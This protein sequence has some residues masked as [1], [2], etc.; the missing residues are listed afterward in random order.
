MGEDGEGRGGVEG[1]EDQGT[2]REGRGAGQRM[3]WQGRNKR[4]KMTSAYRPVAKALILLH[5]CRCALSAGRAH[6]EIVI[7]LELLFWSVQSHAEF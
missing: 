1:E 7:S 3:S 2:G 6:H 4:V 5:D